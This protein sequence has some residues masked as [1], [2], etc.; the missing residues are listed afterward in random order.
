MISQN[1]FYLRY[2]KRVVILRD[3]DHFR[4]FAVVMMVCRCGNRKFN[5]ENHL[6]QKACGND[7][8]IP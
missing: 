6:R 7:M 2:E 3:K 1:I 4:Q 5:D 8:N